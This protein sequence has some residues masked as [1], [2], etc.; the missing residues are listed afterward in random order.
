MEPDRR[1][2]FLLTKPPGSPRSELCFKLIARSENS[3]LYLVGD[4]VYHLPGGI[5]DFPSCRMYACKEDIEARAVRPGKEVTVPKDLY[6]A[7]VEDLMEHCDSE[8]TF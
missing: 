8:Y 2:I 5:E 4:G 1:D 7:L 6:E 3:R